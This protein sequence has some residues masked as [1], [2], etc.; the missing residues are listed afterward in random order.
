MLD[1]AVIVV[2]AEDIEFILSDEETCSDLVV[3]FISVAHLSWV[4]LGVLLVRR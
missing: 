4:G 1:V 3:G 2:A